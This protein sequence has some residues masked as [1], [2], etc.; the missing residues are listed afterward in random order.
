MRPSKGIRLA[1]A[2]FLGASVGHA[3]PARV[4]SMNLCTDQLVMMLADP[5]QIA[6][7]SPMATDEH[8]S[9]MVD[10][11]KSFP[12]NT[13]SAEAIYLD[14]PDLILAGTYT[15]KASVQM[16]QALGLRVEI[17]APAQGFDDIRANIT[18]LGDLLGQSA[19][20]AQ[21]IDA[22]DT[23]LASLQSGITTRPRVALY[24][25]RGYTVGQNSLSSQILE[26][27]GFQNIAAELGLTWGG[28][29]PLE[30]LVML[31]P[32]MVITGRPFTGHSQ[33]EEILRHPA[34]APLKTSAQSDA[35]WVCGTPLVLDAI[36]D[37]QMVHPDKG[38]Q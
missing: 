35:R 24:S 26:A 22:F 31:D 9:A 29:V 1:L 18:R 20:A 13:G 28:I 27:A 17:F 5:D 37:L 34:L 11:A 7:L 3:A 2:L 10:V 36:H 19:R 32:D 25:A 6:S 8:S 33:G 38:P 4:V 12:Q 15:E 14:A 23:R 21:M 16:L 30:T